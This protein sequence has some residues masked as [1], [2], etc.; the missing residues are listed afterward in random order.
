M[1]VYTLSNDRNKWPASDI[2]AGMP[3]TIKVCCI[4]KESD[5]EY[6]FDWRGCRDRAKDLGYEYRRDLTPTR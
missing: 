3:Y 6:D 2:R 1:P 4:R 5:G